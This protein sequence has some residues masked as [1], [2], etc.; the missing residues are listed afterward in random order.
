MPDLDQPA[1]GKVVMPHLLFRKPGRRIIRIV[2]RDV[3]VVI[4]AGGIVDPGVGFGHLVER[5]LRPGRQ[6][7][8][9]SVD[10]ADAENS[11]RRP[12]V[13]LLF[14]QP[15]FVLADEAAAPGEPVLSE[16]NRD[17][18]ANRLPGPG[19]GALEALQF[20]AHRVPIG[21]DGD[22]ELTAIFRHPGGTRTAGQEEQRG[23]EKEAKEAHF[24]T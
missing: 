15:V 16:K 12:T 11:R 22:D 21:R 14:A 19:A 9:V 20:A 4:G 13:P 2:D 17:R 1:V 18:L 23:H 5:E 3:L 24:K 8:V 7:R 10:F 6:R